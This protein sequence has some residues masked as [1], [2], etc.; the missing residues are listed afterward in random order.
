MNRRNFLRLTGLAALAC[1]AELVVDTIPESK[2]TFSEYWEDGHHYIVAEFKQSSYDPRVVMQDIGTLNPGVVKM[3]NRT[4]RPGHLFFHGSE[5]ILNPNKT[6][7]CK[8]TFAYN[9]IG[10]QPYLYIGD[11]TIKRPVFNTIKNAK[12]IGVE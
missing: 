3:G 10:W 9:P 5:A 8:Y 11:K 12:K 7:D 1:S 6:F 2:P 4:V